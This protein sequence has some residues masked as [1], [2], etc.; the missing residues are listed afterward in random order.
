M[1][2]I[3]GFFIFHDPCI[4]IE[5]LFQYNCCIEDRDYCIAAGQ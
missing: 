4:E 5:P 2:F 1:F 3:T